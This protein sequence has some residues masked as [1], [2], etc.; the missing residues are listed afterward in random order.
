[1]KKN[2]LD[3]FREEIDF[4]DKKIILSLSKRFNLIHKI[5]KYKKENNVTPLQTN[6][7]NEVLDSIKKQAEENNL[8]KD[9]VENIWNLI[10]KEALRIEKNIWE[11]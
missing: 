5:W 3:F 11:N 9:F 2:E 10:H 8:S 4:L 1:M 6:R 7:W